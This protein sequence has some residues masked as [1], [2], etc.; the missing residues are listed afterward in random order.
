MRPK[1]TF[2]HG[3]GQDA[4]QNHKRRIFIRTALMAWILVV[5]TVT[6]ILAITV[7][8]QRQ[9]LLEEMRRRAKVA[10]T[11]TAQVA[12]Q[13]IILDDYSVV[14]E[15]CV[16]IVKKNPGL[17]YV[18]LTRQDG[19]SLIHTRKDWI[20]ANLTGIWQPANR[21]GDAGGRIEQNR[22]SDGQAYHLS[23]PLVYSGI[24]W[25]WIHLGLSPDKF[26]KDS[27]VL[28]FR[29]FSAALI[30]VLGGL[31]ASFLYARRLSIPI[32]RLEQFARRI[33][34][35][36]LSQRIELKTQDEIQSLA[37]SFNFMVAELNRSNR[38][39]VKTA[40]QAGMA[41]IAVNVLHN[42]GNVLNSIGVTTQALK[43][44]THRSKANSLQDAVALMESHSD[45]LAE[46]MTD[47]PKGQKLLPY[48]ATLSNH[49][50]NENQA[51]ATALNDLDRHIQHIQEIV[52]LQQTYSRAVGLTERVDIAEVID[53]AL[54]FNAG[55]IKRHGIMVD[56]QFE[57]QPKTII[58]RHKLLQIL[59]N[60]IRNAKQ[61]LRHDNQS[62]KRIVVALQ[63]PRP[64]VMS[65]SVSD[66]GIGIAKENLTRIFQ[67]GFTT[68]R[69][70]HG[71]G[72]HSSALAAAEMNGTLSVESKGSGQGATFTLQLPLR[73]E[74][75]DHGSR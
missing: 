5:F 67:H 11:S 34:S 25:G 27:R 75:T 26:Q 6:F 17:K 23:Y 64:H 62:D 72:L 4:G 63:L 32:Q 70:G 60:L 44:M 33:A 69:R 29:A 61:A 2:R 16:N 18:V 9:Q 46:F 14:V 40:H 31:A 74:E 21:E 52:Q 47:D 39:L 66:N 49:L 57:A 50:R 22:F 13:S 36:D 35:G 71:F 15:H 28:Y 45:H 1:R 38:E 19:F 7:P 51:I 42:V 48:L 53:D 8:F 12:V 65:I 10:Y 68:R 54:Q 3:S 20:Q 73:S 37:E 41:E 58:D 56:K 55:S 59:T 24:D 43:S 30:A